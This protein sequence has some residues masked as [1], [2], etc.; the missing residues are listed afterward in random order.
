MLDGSDT[1]VVSGGQFTVNIESGMPKIYHP[2]ADSDHQRE[3]EGELEDGDTRDD[4]TG[5]PSPL[6]IN[7]HVYTC[8]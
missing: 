1:V 4:N 2:T 8:T 5:T 6:L 7:L 3:E